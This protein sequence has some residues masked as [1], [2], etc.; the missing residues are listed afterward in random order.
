MDTFPMCVFIWNFA[1]LLICNIQ[2]EENFIL[3]YEGSFKT[4]PLNLLCNQIVTYPTTQF[5]PM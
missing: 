3:L 5:F 4:G 1:L 2:S